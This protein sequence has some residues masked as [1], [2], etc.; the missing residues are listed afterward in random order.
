MLLYCCCLVV[1]FCVVVVDVPLCGDVVFVDN[2]FVVL[3][4]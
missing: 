2:V 1:V 4:S 3:C